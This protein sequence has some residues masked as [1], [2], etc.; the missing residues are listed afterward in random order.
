MN[1]TERRGSGVILVSFLVAFMLLMMPLPDWL[2][3]VRPEWVVM[4]VIYWS[5]ALPK[6][7]GVGYAWM[8][9]LIVD[10]IQDSLLGQ[11]ALALALV[12]FLTIRLHQRLRNYP[13]GQQIVT[14]FL[15]VLINFLII[16][17]I[18]GMMGVAP[19]LWQILVPSL[20]TALVWPLIF[21]LM[22]FVRRKFQVA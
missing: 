22:R 17:W 14:V 9:G 1:T 4:V 7:V 5:M 11:H 18:R 19:N 6:R 13:P 20:A 12:A 15:I 16:L 21:I 2:K 10:V 8:A 3:L